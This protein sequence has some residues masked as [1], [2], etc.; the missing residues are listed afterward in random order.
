MIKFPYQKEFV[1]LSLHVKTKKNEKK[2]GKNGEG[3]RREE[4]NL[5]K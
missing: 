1:T 2:K 5:L 3:G 4:A